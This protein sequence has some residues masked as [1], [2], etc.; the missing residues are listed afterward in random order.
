LGVISRV[1]VDA[2]P[3]VAIHF[4]RDE[5]HA[6]C[7]KQV[8][9]LQP[10]LLTCWPV[11]AEAAYLLRS[12]LP[13]VQELFGLFDVGMLELLALGQAEMPALL[14]IMHRYRSLGVQLADAALVHL[15]EREKIDT[16]FT[17]DRRD[18]S[19]FRTA[20]NRVLEIV[21]S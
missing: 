10:P 15:A 7:L 21:P 3:L 1:L 13:A 8:T 11:I 17:L 6:Q 18:F 20:S 9:Q 12:S 16:I 2:G 5:H 19:I 4:K 14:S